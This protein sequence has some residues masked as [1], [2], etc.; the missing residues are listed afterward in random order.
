LRSADEAIAALNA[1]IADG[2]LRPIQLA[3]S[4]AAAGLRRPADGELL[5]PEEALLW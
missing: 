3:S 5:T 4:A 2:A 1:C